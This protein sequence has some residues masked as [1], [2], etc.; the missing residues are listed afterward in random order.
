MNF[1]IIYFVYAPIYKV[2]TSSV[3]FYSTKA[4]K[5]V[6]IPSNKV[7]GYRI[8]NDIM[9][10]GYSD[11]VK[12]GIDNGIIGQRLSRFATEEEREKSSGNCR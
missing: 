1:I 4:K 9:K 11:G 2:M 12:A 10:N 6:E 5:Q 3:S 7:C 8:A